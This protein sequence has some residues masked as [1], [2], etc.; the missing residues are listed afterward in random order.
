MFHLFTFVV[1]FFIGS[2]YA[3]DPTAPLA[4]GTFVL[5]SLPPDMSPNC[6]EGVN[7]RPYFI[8][9]TVVG[10]ATHQVWDGKPPNEGG[11]MVVIRQGDKLVP[12]IPAA[13]VLKRDS[14]GK[15]IETDPVRFWYCLSATRVNFGGT[16]LSGPNNNPVTD[17]P[18]TL[19]LGEFHEVGACGNIFVDQ[20]DPRHSSVEFNSTRCGP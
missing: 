9:P 16:V 12:V 14:S 19:Y 17:G 3:V 8:S 5:G 7:K 13:A 18:V 1:L 6:K 2:A 11:H 20:A 4:P 10:V 15:P